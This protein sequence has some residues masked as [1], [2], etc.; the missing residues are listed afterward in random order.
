MKNKKPTVLLAFVNDRDDYLPSINAERKAIYDLTRDY[1]HTEKIESTSVDSLIDECRK[2][3]NIVILH[4]GGHA[5]SDF[6][7]FESS[8]GTTKANINNLIHIIQQ[9]PNLQLVFLNGCATHGQVDT[10][11][12]AGIKAVIA[13]N[14]GINDK[15]A[16]AFSTRFYKSLAK[17]ETLEKAFEDATNL[18]C[19]EYDFDK[20]AIHIKRGFASLSDNDNIEFPWGLYYNDE[21]VLDWKLP[22]QRAGKYLSTFPKMNISNFVGRKKPLKDLHQNLQNNQATLL[23]NGL[24]GIGKTSLAQK[25]CNEHQ[26]DYDHFVWISQTDTFEN[27]C[28]SAIALQKNLKIKPLENPEQTVQLI[29]NELKQIDGNNLLILDNADETLQPYVDYLPKGNWKILVTSREKMDDRFTEQYLGVLSFAEAKALFTQYFTKINFTDSELKTLCETVGYHTLTLELLAKT[30]AKSIKPIT[31][32][33]V[34]E[35]LNTEQLEHKDL[36]KKIKI[37][38]SNHKEIKTYTYLLRAFSLA[39]LNENELWLLLQFSVMPSIPHDGMTFIK[40]LQLNTED[41]ETEIIETLEDLPQ[42]GWL[43]RTETNFSMHRMI[44]TLIRYQVPPTYEKCNGLVDTFYDLLEL[45]Q[46][47]DNPI[48][49]FQWIEYGLGLCDNIRDNAKQVGSLNNWTAHCFKNIG[50]YKQAVKYF[51]QAIAIAKALQNQNDTN[52]YNNNLALVYRNL[53]RYEEAATL[54]EIALQSDL[55]NFGENHPTVATRQ[56]NLANVYKDLGRYEEAAT[57]L[58]I[59]LQA[60]LNNFGG[61]HPTVATCQSNLAIVY[62]DLGRYEEAANLLEIALQ[63]DLNNFGENH[64]TVATRQSNLATVYGDLGRYEEAATLLEIALQADLNNFGENH[65]TVATHQSNLA[66]VYRDLGRYEEAATLLEIALQ[67]AINNFGENHPTVAALQSNLA[68]VYGNLGRYEEAAT[69]LEIALQAD[70]NNFG[71]NHPTVATRLNNLANVYCSIKEYQKAKDAWL[72]TLNILKSNYGE[73][74]YIDI[75]NQQLERV[76]FALQLESKGIDF[77]DYMK[78][79]QNKKP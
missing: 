9:Q 36:Q 38:H 76:D 44:Q 29:F 27:A 54:L 40:W 31:L 62:E 50:D 19:T 34:I 3:E 5:G 46:A 59:A 64:P 51:K 72:K 63:A 75:V 13:T 58:E 48:D 78:Q 24:G 28:L 43:D 49:K 61:N 8:E 77:G 45:D 68:N 20:T 4:Y 42:K 57:L 17:G 14:I 39:K 26:N 55:N 69:L 41:R 70:L 2:Q 18:I 1:I 6:L 52:A 25:Y 22:K 56:S 12:K 47:K 10:L 65:P 37:A 16:I 53:G 7:L 32:P 71:E 74:P 35:Y 60:D 67:A 30:L 11:L 79:M 21:I 23:L 15:T 66:T 33:Q 73:H